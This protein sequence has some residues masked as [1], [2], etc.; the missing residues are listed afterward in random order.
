MNMPEA[1]KRILSSIAAVMT[2]LAMVPTSATSAEP[3]VTLM[4]LASIAPEGTAWAREIHAFAREIETQTGGEIRVKVYLGG[5]A[6]DE[7]TALERA[8][9]GQLDLLTGALFCQALAPSLRGIRIVGL[10]RSRE[11]ATYVIGRLQTT[12]DEEFRQSGFINLA[13]TV[14]G[15]DILFSRAPITSMADL[16]AQRLWIWNVDPVW[17]IAGPE[18]GMSTVPI[19]IEG[20]GNAYQRQL[21]DGFIALPSTALSF[22]WSSQVGYFSPL[23]VSIAP[24]CLVISTSAFD[25]LSLSQQHVVEAAAAKARVRLDE[26]SSSLEAALVGGLFEKQGLRKTPVTPKFRADFLAAAKEVRDQLGDQFVAPE[27]LARVESLLAEYRSKE[28]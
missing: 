17:K 25:A 13:V 10:Y 14:F 20:A 24:A 27:V 5:V 19:A 23:G 26:V 8:R 18:L 2:A 6:G 4:R 28:P 3:P 7:R 21:I 15:E 11:E 12:L 22:Q 16:R 1:R 9:R